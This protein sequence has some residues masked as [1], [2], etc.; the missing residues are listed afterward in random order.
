LA[1][2]GVVL[3]VEPHGSEGAD[4]SQGGFAA[5]VHFY[6]ETADGTRFFVPSGMLVFGHNRAPSI[7]RHRQFKNES[8]PTRR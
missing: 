2:E 7:A 6:P 1:G 3:R 5:S 8:P 4:A